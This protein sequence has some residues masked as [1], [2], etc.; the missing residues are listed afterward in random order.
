MIQTTHR[1]SIFYLIAVFRHSA[2][3]AEIQFWGLTFPPF[4]A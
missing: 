2:A 3:T 4:S 1:Q